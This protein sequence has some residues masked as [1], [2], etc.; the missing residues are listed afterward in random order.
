MNLYAFKIFIYFAMQQ[1]YTYIGVGLCLF[2]FA[3][4]TE[5]RNLSEDVSSD[6]HM[7]PHAAKITLEQA[8]NIH[9]WLVA[10]KKAKD[11][12]LHIT[13]PY[14]QIGCFVPEE[15]EAAAFKFKAI[16][17]QKVQVNVK[18]QS[19]G[20]KLFAHVLDLS[21]KKFIPQDNNYEPTNTISFTFNA[22]E[23]GNYLLR[24]QPELMKSGHYEVEINT[25]PSLVFPVMGK[26]FKDIGSFWGA[27]RDSGNRWHKGVDI[28]AEKGTPVLAV[29]DGYIY[30]AGS[31][32]LGGNYV[33]LYD[34]LSNRT[35]YYAH[36]DTNLAQEKSYVKAGA[37]LGTIGN[38]G[39]ADKTPPHLHFGIYYTN[40]GAVDPVYFIQQE[41][42]AP[43][44][45]ADP[46]LAGKFV[47]V[48]TPR[49][50]V[51]TAPGTSTKYLTTI[52]E[53]E[54]YQVAA[55]TDNWLMVNLPGNK[56][57]FVNA[58]YV[59][60]VIKST[61]QIAQSVLHPLSESDSLQSSERTTN[62]FSSMLF[63]VK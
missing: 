16:R 42:L 6:K 48:I 43:P 35:F 40:E 27:P 36:L 47:E 63:M 3:G 49:L 29:T 62:A 20:V 41:K 4:C 50:N 1:L 10:A 51:R 9:K 59:K 5:G 61:R 44:I 57:G 56:K 45:I 22:G 17:G 21:Q 25:G 32:L 13:L 11:K 39:N 53:N 54:V 46:A 8:I 18:N 19:D 52:Q 12:P 58:E 60:P 26:G 34:S 37:V 31:N 55:V 28:F 33:R 14:R 30:S 38:T 7:P 2:F 23:T 24:L 15:P